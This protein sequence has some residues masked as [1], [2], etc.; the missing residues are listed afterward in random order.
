LYSVEG[1]QTITGKK[2]G[3]YIAFNP[4]SS[5]TTE[6]W[7]A[8]TLEE[9]KHILRENNA[10]LRNTISKWSNGIYGIGDIEIYDVSIHP[11]VL[12]GLE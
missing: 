2:V 12:R 1:M 7:T 3:K 9:L 5:E 6:W 8:D 4:A 10:T 11:D